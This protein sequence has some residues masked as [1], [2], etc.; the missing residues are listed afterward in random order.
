MPVPARSDKRKRR[1][2]FI[3]TTILERAELKESR[4]SEHGGA[5]NPA[6][7]C[8]PCELLRAARQ[9]RVGHVRGD[10]KR[11]PCDEEAAYG[12]HRQSVFIR[13]SS[14]D[15]AKHGEQRIR[16]R[17]H[18]RGDHQNPAE[19]VEEHR[20][21]D[22]TLR[23][24]AAQREQRTRLEQSGM[25]HIAAIR[26]RAPIPKR[27][28]GRSDKR[29]ERKREPEVPRD[30]GPACAESCRGRC[31][32]ARSFVGSATP[33]PHGRPKA[34]ETCPGA[35]YRAS[36][37]SET[38]RRL[39]NF[40][41]I[42]YASKTN[43]LCNALWFFMSRLMPSFSFFDR[44]RGDLPTNTGAPGTVENTVSAN[45]VVAP[46]AFLYGSSSA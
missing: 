13:P 38:L 31:H 41:P 43:V 3:Q 8:Q 11:K 34:A 20:H 5:G 44:Y 28:P 40:A 26:A 16:R 19:C 36:A 24:R 37:A 4:G 29:A 33:P 15:A 1:T 46:V 42:L 21:D 22:F 6:V 39:C 7:D 2:A 32:V 17:Q 45:V 35:K 12:Q 23:D 25:F 27:D 9:D 18:H 30:V 10:A 14:R